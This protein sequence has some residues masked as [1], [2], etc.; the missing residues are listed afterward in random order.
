MS[1]RAVTVMIAGEGPNEIGRWA[2]HPSYADEYAEIQGDG[3]IGALLERVA[4]GVAQVTH[5]CMLKDARKYRAG[6][7]G[8]GEARTLA[9]LRLDA[10]ERG[11]E[12]LVV[13]RDQDGDA[14]R[15]KTLLA[16]HD[17]PGR[18]GH[19]G[20]VVGV[21]TRALEA[22]ILAALS[23]RRTESMSSA[24]LSEELERRGIPEKDTEAYVGAI[25]AAEVQ[26]IPTDAEQLHAFLERLRDQV[27]RA[28]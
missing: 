11:I 15:A 16:F 26:S 14:D 28:A 25:K 4:D 22:W 17:E 10:Q 1:P 23:A 21:P 5:G 9:A 8:D 13:L 18:G 27:L 20:L 24:A 3:V 19:P 12:V 2:R 7:H 6:R